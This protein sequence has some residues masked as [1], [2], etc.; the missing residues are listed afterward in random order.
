MKKIATVI[1]TCTLMFSLVAC[2]GKKSPDSESTKEQS[3]KTEDTNKESKTDGASNY[4]VDDDSK[5]PTGTDNDFYYNTM[6]GEVKGIIGEDDAIVS[7]KNH[8]EEHRDVELVYQGKANIKDKEM[9]QVDMQL[10]GKNLVSFYINKGSTCYVLDKGSNLCEVYSIP[11]E[12][13]DLVNHARDI[14]SEIYYKCRNYDN[15]DQFETEDE[16]TYYRIS[17]ENYSNPEK[18][19][20]Y[21]RT[22]FTEEKTEKLMEDVSK[23][24][25]EKD[26][27]YYVPSVDKSAD[28]AYAFVVYRPKEVTADK[29]I[30]NQIFYYYDMDEEGEHIEGLH[31]E[32]DTECV[33]VKEG[34]QWLLDECELPNI[35]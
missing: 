27:G 26:G 22:L 18:M 29:I 5:W 13:S 17:E 12:E 8:I 33:L 4:L 7:V 14:Q 32:A 3:S 16:T 30:F 25:I 28:E 2:G 24:W 9:A 21:L 34:D 6:E 19:R 15:N 35:D 20:A 23:R 11:V 10:D 31:K 1:L